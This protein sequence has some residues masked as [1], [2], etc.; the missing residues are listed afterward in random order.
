MDACQ[1][2]GAGRASAS[3]FCVA[4][5]ALV[6]ELHLYPIS[7]FAI[8]GVKGVTLGASCKD[9]LMADDGCNSRVTLLG[10]S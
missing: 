6:I 7:M 9:S 4:S 10:S 1:I 8:V 5:R 3:G 2:D